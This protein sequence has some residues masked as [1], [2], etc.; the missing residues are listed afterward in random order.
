MPGILGNIPASGTEIIKVLGEEHV[1]TA[2]ADR[3]HFRGF[4]FSNRRA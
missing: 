3:L 2:Q 4:S 1:K